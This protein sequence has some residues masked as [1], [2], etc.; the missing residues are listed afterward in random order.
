VV[1]VKEI[2]VRPQIGI[3]DMKWRVE[4][5]KEWLNEGC[6]L[7]FK[8]QAFGRIGF[9]PELIEET[10]KKFINL[11]EPMKINFTPLKKLTPVMYESTIVKS[12]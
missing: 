5:A 3:H 4:N 7:K 10:F 8:I 9:K 6:Q 12:K 11:F 2:K 1:K